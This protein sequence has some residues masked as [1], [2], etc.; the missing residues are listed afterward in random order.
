MNGVSEFP[1]FYREFSKTIRQQ[2]E[3]DK[4]V[5]SF[6]EFSN[7]LD[8][9][10]LR[11]LIEY[12][13]S[14]NKKTIDIV[15]GKRAVRD[16]F[17][18]FYKQGGLFS[19]TGQEFL[20]SSSRGVIIYTKNYMVFSLLVDAMARSNLSY[21][22]KNVIY[23]SQKSSNLAELVILSS[24]EKLFT[25]CS[26]KKYKLMSISKFLIGGFLISVMLQQVVFFNK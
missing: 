8:V 20:F 7:Y 4:S 2:P 14:F 22:V 17:S 18:S 15:Y 5:V 16:I 21:L 6:I 10:F 26:F 3:S 24:P 11:K 25:E 12:F 13:N 19:S 1:F 9:L 23:N